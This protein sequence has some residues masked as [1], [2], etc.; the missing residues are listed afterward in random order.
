MTGLRRWLLTTNHKD[1]GVLYIITALLFGLIGGVFAILMRSQLMFVAFGRDLIGPSIYNQLVTM[2]G[3][4]MVLFFLSPV[5][6]GLAN[7]MVPIQIGAKDM[8]FPRLNAL[9]YW[10]YLFGGLV[11]TSGFLFGGAAATGW[12]F[13]APLASA[14]YSPQVGVSLAL[15]GLVM[16]IISVTLSTVNFLT[17]ILYLRAPGM[18][19]LRMPLFTW[20]IF[21]T[22]AMM[23]FAFPSLAAAGIELLADRLLG[24]VYFT[25]EAG[26]S[27][28]W[29]HLFWFF[30]HP[31]VYI[32]LLPGLGAVAE[33]IPVFA[34]RPIYGKNVIITALAAATVLSFVVWGHHMFITGVNPVF[35][36]FMVLTTEFISIPFGLIFL[37]Y[38]ASLWGGS[39]RLKTP[40]LFA[41]GVITLF[42]FG[43]VSGVFNSSVALDYRIRGTFWLLA[44]FHYALI[45][46]GVV[47]VLAG[48]YY[49]FPK[50][51][52]RM[53][54]E[55]LG[56]IHFWLTFIGVN[57][58][59]FPQFFLI[60]M[61]RRVYTYP[62]ELGWNGL[63]IIST[64]GAYIILIGQIIFAYNLYTSLKR[65]PAAGADP[66]G[67]SSLEWSISSPPPP[68]NFERQPVIAQPTNQSRLREVLK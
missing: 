3:I 45:G 1:I 68:H 63:N 52:G 10:L 56:R 60:D 31:E 42:I 17:T 44:H 4:L 15:A 30:A 29:D 12:T 5:G 35:R 19:L 27:I 41:L 36:K 6:F 38:I 20:S 11:A 32:V 51:T 39:I 13:Y 58:A 28:L 62:T 22:T 49:W 14:R 67:G 25:S 23:L 24:T 54:D 64:S 37:T 16:L 66:W 2:H 26:G 7:Y 34:R 65:G 33:V 55:G 8:A 53:Y 59:F 57:I 43:G 50:M 40:M 61:P 9:S 46:G 48:I 47:G 21:F 18:T